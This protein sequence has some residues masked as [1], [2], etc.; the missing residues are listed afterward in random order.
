MATLPKAIYMFNTIPI[1]IPMTFFTE[2]EKL[3][4][5][6]VWKCTSSQIA[7]L[8]LSKKSNNGGITILD[9]KQYYRIIIKRTWYWYKNRQED[10]RI[11]MEDL[12]INPCINSQL[13]FDKGIQNS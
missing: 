11:R 10:Q 3:I 13:I 7:T 2:I 4:L 9:F 5:K 1:K 12:D 8:I 6:Y